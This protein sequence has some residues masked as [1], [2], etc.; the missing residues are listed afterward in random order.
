MEPQPLP[1]GS[2][3]LDCFGRSIQIN[4]RLI[5]ANRRVLPFNHPGSFGER[6]RQAIGLNPNVAGVLARSIRSQQD[7]ETA[8]LLSVV[9]NENRLAGPPTFSDPT[10]TS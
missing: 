1:V 9:L 5:S 10:A 3:C 8:G 4:Y 2:P 7:S 6:L